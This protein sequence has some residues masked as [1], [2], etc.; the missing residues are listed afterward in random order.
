MS[1]NIK[2]IL[3]G[4]IGVPALLFIFYMGGI[5]FLVFSLIVGCICLWEL[6]SLFEK[7]GFHPL[8]IFS[9]ILS[10]LLI[11]ISHFFTEIF[12]YA[13][14]LFF[15]LIMSAEVLRGEKKNTLNPL[16]LIFGVVYIGIFFSL[17][18]IL[19]TLYQGAA[20]I[21]NNILF[22]I[23]LIWVTDT[24]AYFGGRAFGKRPLSS[25]SPKKTKEGA[26]FG[27]VFA[28]AAALLFS[29]LFP[30]NITLMDAVIV[31]LIVGIFGQVGDLFESMIKRY[32][33]AKDSSN[34]IPGHGGALDR[35][36]SFI[37]IS[38][39]IYIYYTYIRYLIQ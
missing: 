10:I 6:F 29:F 8:K 25:V 21:Y 34:I 28:V 22:V 4:I 5:Y 11:L 36:D 3:V 19:F 35:F 31:G 23:I 16:I 30:E 26:V 18:N 20:H 7:K 14:L 2:R 9:I 37:F 32:A 27:F 1:N 13:V 17:Y 15:G 33:G 24:S 38:P 39:F 12:E